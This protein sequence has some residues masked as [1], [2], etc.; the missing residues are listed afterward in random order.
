MAIARHSLIDVSGSQSESSTR[1]FYIRTITLATAILGF[2]LSACSLQTVNSSSRCGPFGD[3]PAA[4]IESPKPFCWDGQLL[5][6]W[7][8]SDGTKRWACLFRP[9]KPVTA[10]LPLLVDL[11]RSL[12]SAGYFLTHL[13]ALNNSEELA[14][15]D[16]RGFFVLAPQGR[17][18]RH[19]YPFPDDT[20][21]G[22]DNWY[23]Q[24]DPSG[25]VQIGGITYPENV[26]AAAIDHFISQ[27]VASE[28]IDP[29][30]IYITGWSNGASMAILYALNRPRIA[31]AAVYSAPDPFGA[32]SDP[33]VQQPVTKPPT[34]NNEVRILNSKVPLLHLYNSC[35]A[36]GLCPNSDQLTR[37]LIATSVPIRDVKLDWV[38]HQVTS[39][40]TICGTE[41]EGNANFFSTPAG[42]TFGL[43][44]HGRWPDAWND[45]MF[46]FLR[47]HS[48]PSAKEATRKDG[49]WR[50]DNG[51][52]D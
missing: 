32:L 38:R 1:F 18:T 12:F 45:V 20:G 44:N 17:K 37:D 50:Q 6:P 22:W 11:H 19:F 13:S 40:S 51:L 48:L 4:A 7:F 25:D 15:K 9:K 31:A 46:E 42:W 52:H 14:N 29:Q 3:P 35:D 23:R 36:L 39:C 49:A 43:L 30:R 24:F 8:D 33:C 27:V 5:G 2:S 41:P 26:D 34:S 16:F 47:A 10:K 21:S 28:R